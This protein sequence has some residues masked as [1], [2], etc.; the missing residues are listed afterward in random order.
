M[1]QIGQFLLALV[2]LL[3]LAIGP[4]AYRY[5]QTQGPIVA[6][7]TLGG[8]SP[9]GDTPEAVTSALRSAFFSPVAVYYQ[10]T[11]LVLRPR[12]V[13]F[14][15]DANAMVEEAIARSQGWRFWRGF[16]HRML[17]IPLEPE[18]VP[19]RYTVDGELLANWL[20]Q[21]AAR[22]DRAP[23]PARPMPLRAGHIPTDTIPYLPAQPGLRLDAQA[24]VP[25]L[26]KALTSRSHREVHLVVVEAPPPPPDMEE[27]L[28]E[29]IRKRVA[30]FPGI[31]S[32]FIRDPE[33]QQEIGINPE[34]AFAGMS[35]MKIAILEEVYRKLDNEPDVETTRLLTET[36][37]LSGNY[38]ANLLLA[39]I[40]DGDS[41]AGAQRL[42][43]SMRELGL[44]NTFMATPYDWEAMPAYIHTPANSRTD[45]TTHPDPHMQTTAKDMGLLM[46][47]V[48]QCSQGGGA[49]LAAYP[50][51][52]TPAECQTMLSLLKKNPQ[53][54]LLVAG[55]PPGARIA[56]KHGFI[57]DSH[58][59]VGVVWGPAG[60]YVIAVYLYRPVWLEWH[61]SSPLMAEISWAAWAYFQFLEQNATL[62]QR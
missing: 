5:A 20:S 24:S 26:L 39:L 25:D 8:V 7:I 50:K 60:P 16:V 55:L 21:V 49:L 58:G 40:G 53:R 29:L 52:I 27:T 59:D 4:R 6:D 1:R 41:M 35:T 28:G 42:T 36:I 54:G 3:G 30:E 32:V 62:P 57:D 56:H 10:D 12:E 17:D 51:E 33:R 15:M 34:I 43:A 44:V 9:V 31:A 61:L 18:D 46:E 14:Q 47:M 48:V 45:V 13:G 38:T 23:V 37:E 22:Y 11:R 2:V 19:L